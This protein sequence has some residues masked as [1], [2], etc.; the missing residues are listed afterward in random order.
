MGESFITLN[1]FS[2]DCCEKEIISEDDDVTGKWA[3]IFSFFPSHRTH[4]S[5]QQLVIN[6][7]FMTF[8]Q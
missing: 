5:G 6:N 1:L 8:H 2:Q 7:L 3:S 4:H